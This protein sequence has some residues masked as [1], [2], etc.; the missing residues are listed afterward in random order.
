MDHHG[1][2]IL[3]PVITPGLK[4]NRWTVTSERFCIQ[5]EKEKYR[6]YHECVCECGTSG[7][8][9]ADALK[10][11]GSLSCGCL[12]HEMLSKIAYRHGDHAT[13]I[14]KV[15]ASM[16]ARCLTATHDA[17]EHYGG[18]GITVCEE[19]MDYVA[20][21]D[22]ALSSGY[23]NGLVLDR[24]DNNG[25]YEPQNCRWATWVESNRNTRKNLW[26]ECGGVRRILKDWAADSKLSEST[27]SKRLKRGWT[28]R[29]ALYTPCRQRVPIIH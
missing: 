20:F 11:G 19:W 24:K 28:A 22:W 5:D 9:R 21:R 23:K 7:R 15:W 27:I 14:Y 8:V 29:Q 26:I 18:R 6:A 2:A 16:K 13:P 3:Y 1:V 4:I 17:W 25:N 10:R 12:Q